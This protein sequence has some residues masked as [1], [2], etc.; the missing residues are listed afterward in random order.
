MG[1]DK[2]FVV[3]DASVRQATCWLLRAAAH[4][5]IGYELGTTSAAVAC[6]RDPSPQPC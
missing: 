6:I 2:I 1:R 5:A 4:D 3:D